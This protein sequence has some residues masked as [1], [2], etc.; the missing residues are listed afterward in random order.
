VNLVKDSVEGGF[1]LTALIAAWLGL[2]ST[3]LTII[4]TL[5]TI[6]W[7]VIRISETDWWRN[8][9]WFR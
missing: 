5:L 6:V 1:A 4:A 3:G 9:K 2:L 8:R 7:S